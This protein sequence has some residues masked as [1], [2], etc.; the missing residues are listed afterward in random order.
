MVR[1]LSIERRSCGNYFFT[2]R[3]KIFVKKKYSLFYSLQDL[4]STMFNL[5]TDPSA[6]SYVHVYRYSKF[7]ANACK[8]A[9]E[10]ALESF[11]P[12][13]LRN[14]FSR[15]IFSPGESETA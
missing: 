11:P 1:T 8:H 6:N 15:F 2:G 12:L 5:P 13:P 10:S 3:E 9:F 14:R 7:D 4:A